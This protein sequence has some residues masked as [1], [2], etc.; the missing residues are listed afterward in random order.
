[1][2]SLSQAIPAMRVRDAAAAVEIYRDKLGFDVLHHDGGFAVMRRDAA[3]VH[4]WQ[5]GDEP[6]RRWV[7]S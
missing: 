5:A 4:L 7:S 3:V 2:V 1:M 6:R